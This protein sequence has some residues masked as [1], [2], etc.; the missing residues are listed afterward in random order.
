MPILI[1]GM[2][3]PQHPA[4][5]AIRTRTGKFIPVENFPPTSLKLMQIRAQ[6]L[7]KERGTIELRSVDGYPYNCVGMI[8]ASRRAWIE[9]DHIYDLLRED[10]YKRIQVEDVKPGDIVLYKDN[11]APLHVGLVIMVERIGLTPNIKVVSKWGKDPEF[12]HFM[13]DVPSLLGKPVEFY[14]DRK[15]H[16]RVI[17]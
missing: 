4:E 16:E 14:T 13:E 1:P 10:D 11:G 6:A 15:T 2:Q 5:N 12:I 7:L 8:F 9:I 3:E 17:V